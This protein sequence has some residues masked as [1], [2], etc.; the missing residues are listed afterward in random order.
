LVLGVFWVN[1][2]YL[3]ILI[4]T[5]LKKLKFF[6]QKPIRIKTHHFF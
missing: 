1:K 2:K 6:F 5:Y 4:H 3:Y